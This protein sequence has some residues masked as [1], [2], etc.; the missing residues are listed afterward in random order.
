MFKVRY[1][2]LFVIALSAYSYLNLKFTVG[3]RLFDFEIGNITLFLTL[4]VCVLLIWELNRLA[5]KQLDRFHNLVNKKIHPLI[6]FFGI[7]LIN[8]AVSSLLIMEVLYPIVGM[9]FQINLEHLS[10]LVAFGFRINLFLNCIN[11]IF[12]YVERLKKSEL[13]AAEFKKQSAEARYEALR[14][15]INPHFL[16]NS[17]NTLTSLV[18]KDADTSARFIEQLASVYRYLLNNQD[19][20]LVPL[21]QELHFLSAYLYLLK[22]RFGENILINQSISHD[23]K[24]LF[25]AP[26]VLQILIENAIKHNVVSR[27]QQLQIDLFTEN[28]SIVVRNNL[29][30]KNVKEASTQIGLKNIQGRYQFLSDKPIKIERTENDFTVKLPLIQIYS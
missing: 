16:F 17:F 10:L 27:K 11:A 22:M 3:N 4:T 19:N 5:E 7:S 30:E 21:S 26:A 15:Q 9:P 25:V 13:D 2:Y 29:Q 8:V 28:D 18:H 14:N 24:E 20:R 1:R 23:R 12:Y 6:L